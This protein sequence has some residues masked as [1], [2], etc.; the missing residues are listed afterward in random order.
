MAGWKKYF[1]IL[2]S[3]GHLQ[4][5]P[6]NAPRT[7]FGILFTKLQLLPRI[8]LL[9]HFSL[10]NGH[11][12]MNEEKKGARIGNSGSKLTMWLQVLGARGESE[13]GRVSLF[14]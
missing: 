7:W 9:S 6:T 2:I 12:L 8:L 11:R 1:F 3:K 13:M 5:R 4:M 10:D 14:L